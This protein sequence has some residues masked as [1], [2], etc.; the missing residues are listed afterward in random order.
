VPLSRD[1]DRRARQLA[2]L[3]RGGPANA[4]SFRPDQASPV[5]K[6]G[7]R[8][9][10]PPRL[11]LTETAD[12]IVDALAATVPL[13]APDGDVMPQFLPAIEAAAL[14]LV[15]I[16]RAAAFLASHGATDQRGRFR[17]ENEAL[18]R[19]IE[20]FMRTLDRLGATPRSY[21]ALGFD[22]TRTARE[23]L[24]LRWMRDAD[25]TTIAGQEAGEGAGDG[26]A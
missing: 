13:R 1:P 26:R 16:R 11:L 19:T 23:D 2:N 6:H 5:L 9:R 12:E 22:V 20:G 25:A 21:A 18:T 14:L 17:P 15:Q 4:G 8:S 3:R 10:R 7:L 24:A